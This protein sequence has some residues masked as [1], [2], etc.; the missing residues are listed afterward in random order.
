MNII[1]TIDGIDRIA[2][3]SEAQEICRN[4]ETADGEME[5]KIGDK[6]YI[7]G[8]RDMNRLCMQIHRQLYPPTKD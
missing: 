8:R 2:S 3:I 1:I 4:I 7:V 6:T 5:V